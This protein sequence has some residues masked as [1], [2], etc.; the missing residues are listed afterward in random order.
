MIYAVI[1]PRCQCCQRKATQIDG[2]DTF[3]NN[4]TNRVG[5]SA[6]AEHYGHFR[7][8]ILNESQPLLP[9]YQTKI[10]LLASCVYN[11]WS[12]YNN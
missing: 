9:A 6:L 2:N 5:E 1:K 7:D 4:Y 3:D 12:E 11:Y 8:S 10:L